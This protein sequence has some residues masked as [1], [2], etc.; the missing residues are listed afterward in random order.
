MSAVAAAGACAVAGETSQLIKLLQRRRL[1][2]NARLN[3]RRAALAACLPTPPTVIAPCISSRANLH[4]RASAN[5]TRR[6]AREDPAARA[7][8]SGSLDAGAG[9]RAA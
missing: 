8:R 4:E 2:D 9:R 3:R 5:K 7:P 6:R 1:I